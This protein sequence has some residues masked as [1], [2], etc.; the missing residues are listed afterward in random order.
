MVEAIQEDGK[1]TWLD[2]IRSRFLHPTTDSFAACANV[3]LGEADEDD[4][5]DPTR[6][7]VVI[8][9]SESSGRSLED[10][11]SRCARAGPAQAAGNEPVHEVVGDD[12]GIP[13]ETAHQVESRKKTK[14]GASERKEKGV[15]DKAA[16]TS[17]KRP[18]TLPVLD[19]VVVSD[20]LS[21]LGA[22]EKPRGSDPHDRSTLT[23]M[24]KK[25]A[26]EDKKR[27]LGEQPAA[28]LALKKAKL[29]KEVPLAPSESDIDMGIFSGD[30]GNLLE[31]IYAASA[32]T[33]K[34]F[35]VES[36][37]VRVRA[38]L[39]FQKS[40]ILLLLHRGQLIYPLL[41]MILLKRRKRMM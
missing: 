27:K 39:I 5:L 18:S 41:V 23:E 40:L 34:G 6:E 32:P 30:R 10:L 31:E 12:E 8:L 38:G 13:V 2:Q 1:P 25:K 21:G 16:D 11:I 7:E 22:G 37:R 35:T 3:A 20:T 14:A 17:R 24:M 26:L 9:S 28:L 29:Q 15:E 4:S 36:S 33:G 19:Y